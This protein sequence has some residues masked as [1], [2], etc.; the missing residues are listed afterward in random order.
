MKPQT[1]NT[2]KIA[3]ARAFSLLSPRQGAWSLPRSGRGHFTASV[4]I[5]LGFLSAPLENVPSSDTAC[6]II[7][8]KKMV[9][10][11]QEETKIGESQSERERSRHTERTE[12]LNSPTVV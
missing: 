7:I 5:E 8:H 9:S 4:R 12:C 1:T 6:L 3:F 11:R 10:E 2:T